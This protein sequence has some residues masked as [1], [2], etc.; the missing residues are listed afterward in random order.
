MVLLITLVIELIV[1]FYILA[2]P[3][4]FNTSTSAT[5]DRISTTSSGD[6]SSKKAVSSSTPAAS[7]KTSATTSKNLNSETDGKLLFLWLL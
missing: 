1:L 6:A 5:S 7:D 4:Q 3:D 2:K